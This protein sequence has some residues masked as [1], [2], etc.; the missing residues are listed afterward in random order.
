MNNEIFP[1]RLRVQDTPYYTASPEL[2]KLA[3]ARVRKALVEK[4]IW[5]ATDCTIKSEKT[6]TLFVYGM[7]CAVYGGQ[8]KLLMEVEV[9]LS[10]EAELSLA[11]ACIKEKKIQL[12]CEEYK[13]RKD[14]E[15]HAAIM[16]VHKEMF[17]N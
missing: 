12:A 7:A 1:I 11:G 9:D 2:A 3:W 14:K 6:I 10:G 17:G 15:D 4:S 13:R 8:G 16:A 5:Y